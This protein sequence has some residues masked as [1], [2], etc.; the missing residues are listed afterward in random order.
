[1]IARHVASVAGIG[2]LPK[3]PGTWGSL[4]ALPAFYVLHGVGQ[5]PL[6]LNCQIGRAHV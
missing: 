1:M 3:A 2:F 5:F 4:I 6:V